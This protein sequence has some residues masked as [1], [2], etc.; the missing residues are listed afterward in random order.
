M[1]QH[2]FRTF[3][4]FVLS[5]A[6]KTLPMRSAGLEK[7]E[8]LRSPVNPDVDTW[9]LE[10]SRSI[11]DHARDLTH[12]MGRLAGALS[13]LHS[14]VSAVSSQAPAYVPLETTTSSFGM[15]WS[16]DLLFDG[17]P[18]PVAASTTLEMNDDFLFEDAPQLSVPVSYDSVETRASL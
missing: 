17:E 16:D 1:S 8:P 18:L 7:P 3:R 2:I 12:D 14:V 11:A 5:A 13:K 10:P 15:I 4:Q 9:L 6:F